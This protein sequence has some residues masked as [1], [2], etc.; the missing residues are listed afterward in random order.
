MSPLATQSLAIGLETT[1]GTEVT[2]TDYIEIKDNGI[3]NNLN[4][5]L[6]DDTSNTRQG[7]KKSTTGQ[8]E[9]GGDIS[10]Y[11]YPDNQAWF[12]MGVLG[13]WSSETASGETIVYEH[14]ITQ[15]DTLPSFTLQQDRGT[16]IVRWKGVKFNSFTITWSNN[17]AEISVNAIAKD[18]ETGASYTP[19]NTDSNPFTFDQC[20]VK[21]G[22]DLTD[23]A[24]NNATDVIEGE[25]MYDNQAEAR[26]A[27]GDG[28]ATAI[29]IDPKVAIGKF[30]G[31]LF[32]DD[33]TM[34]DNYRNQTKNAM[35][36]SFVGASIGNSENYEITFQV[37]KMNYSSH[38]VDYSS[39]EFIV[40]NIEADF[41]YD[42][43]E[44]KMISCVIT[45]LTQEYK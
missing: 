4:S 35:I 6:V 25:F 17:K 21:F 3:E 19:T 22:T 41:M 2:P 11:L 45:N 26:Y 15:A 16:D 37:A 18:E 40:E 27:S 29:K 28:T 14:T 39:G 5:E 44:S 38:K 10:A 1:F 30:T 42:E 31:K 12:I 34:R 7:M 24:G 13:T 23:A 36:L 9:V 32:F 43:N 8:K 33:T 20:T